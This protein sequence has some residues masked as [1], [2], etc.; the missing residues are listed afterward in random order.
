MTKAQK[1]E[2]MSAAQLAEWDAEIE[3]DFQRTV[4]ANKP[5]RQKRALQHIGCPREFLIDVCRL[6]HGRAALLVALAI[7]RQTAVRRRQTVTLNGLE[8]AEYSVA[9]RRKREALRDL[10][11][12]GIVELRRGGSGKA[13]EVTLLWRSAS[14]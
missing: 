7:Y 6:T 5:S 10:A 2:T 11:N 12:A 14:S 1:A 4:A 13:T 9:P 3:A 8:L